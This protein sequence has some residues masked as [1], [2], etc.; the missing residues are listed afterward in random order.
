MI[1]SSC[2]AMTEFTNWDKVNSDMNSIQQQYAQQSTKQQNTQSQVS[3]TRQQAGYVQPRQQTNG[4]SLARESDAKKIENEGASLARQTSD[5]NKAQAIQLT[6]SSLAN[7]IRNGEI[8]LT[9]AQ[10]QL[11]GSQT[12]QSTQTQQQSI[13]VAGWYYT[14]PQYANPTKTTISLT[15]QRHETGGVYPQYFILS[16]GGQSQSS[17]IASYDRN[18]GLY[19][20][21][22]GSRKI[23]FNM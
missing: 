14:N 11:R 4:N 18:T 3:Q 17:V 2:A 13:Q 7:K 22:L 23:Y 10:A 19:V 21:T 6:A 1:M 20:F 12:Q 16:A 9:Q 8:N 5:Y 15:V